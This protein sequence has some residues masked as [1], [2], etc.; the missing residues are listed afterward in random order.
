MQNYKSWH[1]INLCIAQPN[2]D[3]FSE[4]FIRNQIK[5]L[6]PQLSISEGYYPSVS[7]NRSILPFPLNF[8]SIRGIIRNIAPAT[9]HKLY[10]YQLAKVLKKLKINIVLA[11]YGVMG[12][13]LKDTC[14]IANIPLVIHFHGFDAYHYNIINKYR[15]LYLK[16]FD[17]CS[18][19]VVVSNDMKNEVLKLGAPEEKIILNPYGVNPERFS[20]GSPESSE[21]IFV[22]A[23]RLVPK[24]KPENT[25]KAFYKVL[26][27][28]PDSK[29]HI[30]GHGPLFKESLDL[31]KKLKIE[32]SVIFEGI[33][34]PDKVAEIL[35]SARC[36]VQ[37]SVRAIDGDSEGTPN[38]ILEASATG[39]PIVS[40]KHAGIQEAIVHNKTGYLVEEDDINGMAEYMIKLAEDPVLAGKLGRSGR[41]HILNNY[42]ESE[43]IRMLK[44]IITDSANRFYSDRS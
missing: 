19:I 42:L 38:T 43:R 36:F 20:G 39:L 30:V 26:Q 40:T 29:L 21:R 41:E 9:Y 5:N 12:G 18:A 11:N 27:K 8:L 34:T 33:K 23:G 16:A 22:F 28:Y 32:N 7:D 17:Y 1:N 2:K 14:Q 44:V 31:V 10:S 15:N 3:A 24:K 37:H 25:I 35:R 6:S 13:S 4:T